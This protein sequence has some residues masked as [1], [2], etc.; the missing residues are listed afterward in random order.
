MRVR[1]LLFLIATLAWPSAKDTPVLQ[2][3]LAV[4]FQPAVGGSADHTVR[5]H[6]MLYV[7]AGE[8]PSPFVSPGPFTA[9]WEGVIHLELRDRFIFQ[10]EL[11]GSLKLE[12][13]G[14]PVMEAT[15]TGGMTEPT[16]RIRLNSRSN[17]LKATF[18]SPEKG[19]AFFRLYWS[20]PDY[21]N[22]PI[23]PKYLK[24]APNE[25]LAKG[26]ALR[27]G[28]QLAAEHRCFKCHA[29]D[30]P[31]KGMPELAMD[32]PS[33]EGIGLRRGV[34]WMADWVLYP[35]KL[36]PSA[37]M[38]AMLHEATA[39]SDA[40]AIAAYLGSL[41]SGQPVKPAPVDADAISAGQALYKQLNC[42]ACHT[43]EKEPSAP[44]KLA[45]GQAQRKFGQ[46]GA[47]SA[48]LQNP[49]A[50]Y[51]WIR[52]PNFALAE[53]EAN[54][55]AA[56]LFS[57]AVPAKTDSPDSDASKIA[58]GKKMVSSQ[59]C[60]N[61]HSMKLENSFS[62]VA[63]S[64]LAKGC[65]ADSPE[66]STVRFGLAAEERVALRLFLKEGRESLGQ[67]SLAEFALRQTD[68][69]NCRN[70]HGQMESVPPFD[71]LGGKL[72]PGWAEKLLLGTLGERPRPW[73]HARMPAFP[74][75]AS[76]VAKGLAMLNGHSPVTPEEPP[77][78]PEKAKVGR[79]LVSANGGFFCFS[80]HA[81]GSLKPAQVFDAQGINL[82]KVGDR[83]LP[84][85]FRR[86]MSS[87]LRVDP[88]TKMPAYFN[89]GQSALFDILD[90]DA[91]QQ[92]EALHHYIRLGG[93]MVPPEAPG[94]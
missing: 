24:H 76:G 72:K 52:M 78:E 88:Q 21:G 51:K 23:P 44:G 82:A 67:A 27:R 87:P 46:A 9:E 86:W 45:L 85:Y 49:Q 20:T 73:L 12:L 6:F 69:S 53:K 8:A 47:L 37:K 41:K 7:P 34:D 13:N 19:D 17:T 22:E 14:N 68:D 62:V 10:A 84:E 70:C 1:S 83:L 93:E 3:G 48:F 38:P 36:R 5:P 15:G 50:H 29:A 64:D 89:Q 54:A 77:L 39:E 79:K 35:K 33:F 71:V 74:A 26:K 65:L 58:A 94:Q 92:I 75:R 11:N 55:L 66:G 90:G 56:F 16:K 63:I 61:C 59:G 43:L 31:V 28:R 80:C 60:L 81:I 40:R 25:N 18:T 57:A 91:G 4:T 42:A 32:A 2:D 30:A